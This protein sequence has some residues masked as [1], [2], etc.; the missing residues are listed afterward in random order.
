VFYFQKTAMQCSIANDQSIHA[1]HIDE[2]HM[3][4][5]EVITRPIPPVLDE[6]KV[7]SLMNTIIS[8]SHFVLY[9]SH[10]TPM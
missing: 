4:P 8:V 2:I 6:A 5:F 3:V 10:F 9:I 1:A 7:Q